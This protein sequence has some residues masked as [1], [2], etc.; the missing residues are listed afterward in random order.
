MDD[1]R[2]LEGDELFREYA[3]LME[4][5]Q[6]TRGCYFWKGDNGN[7]AARA[8]RAKKYEVPEFGWTEGGHTYTAAFHFSQTRYKTYAHG[9]YTRDGEKTTILAIR[10]SINRL[11]EN[12][13]EQTGKET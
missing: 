9:V 3:S 7:L 8:W 13:D 4:S 11:K 12:K 5:C 10:N 1:I 6:Q 2:I